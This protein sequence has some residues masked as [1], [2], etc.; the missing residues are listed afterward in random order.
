M[1]RMWSATGDMIEPFKETGGNLYSFN[2][3]VSDVHGN[4]ITSKSFINRNAFNEELL[5]ET[6]PESMEELGKPVNVMIEDMTR[7]SEGDK[8]LSL[9]IE[10]IMGTTFI[11]EFQSGFLFGSDK[12][13]VVFPIRNFY[14]LKLSFNKYVKLKNT[15]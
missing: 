3:F 1:F 6:R 4:I 7:Y 14:G 9:M 12:R 8:P 5:Y 13:Q 15:A 11:V 2:I 10:P